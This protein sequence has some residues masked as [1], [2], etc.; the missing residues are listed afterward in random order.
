MRRKS[1][2]AAG[3]AGRFGQVAGSEPGAL[4]AAGA[5]PLGAGK[6]AGMLL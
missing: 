1:P 4:W 5:G 3:S 2:D 6:N